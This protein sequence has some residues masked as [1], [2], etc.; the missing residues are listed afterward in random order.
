MFG[1][2]LGGRARGGE[3][4][5]VIGKKPMS[6]LEV[7]NLSKIY[8]DEGASVAALDDV[9]FTLELGESLAVCGASGAGKSTLLNIL[10][11]LD[12]PTGGSI[13]L[14]GR[15]LLAL[16]ESDEAGFRQKY[17]GFVFQFHHLLNDFSILEN[18]MMP[19]LIQNVTKKR[20]QVDATDL[21]NQV[22]LLAKRN[23]HPRELSGGEQ[24]RVA[25]AR[26]LVHRPQLVLADEP[27]GNLD[28]TNARLVFDL[29]CQL[30][31]DL[32]ATLVVVTHNE[33]FAKKMKRCLHLISG[34]VQSWQ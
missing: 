8:L 9:S 22:G 5:L 3:T 29:L 17:L 4:V 33:L 31:H 24:Q 26:A 13:F 27:T 10:G 6:T 18:V 11:G 21:L 25:I 30:N 34:R 28:D 20:A 2:K 23:R 12:R 14:N 1:D 16:S 15:D 32:H 19:L 7:K